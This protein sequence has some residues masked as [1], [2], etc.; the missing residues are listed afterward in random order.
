MALGGFSSGVIIDPS[1]FSVKKHK[2]LRTSYVRLRWNFWFDFIPQ[3]I[4]IR[5][6]LEI[7]KKEILIF[8]NV[9][10]SE[11]LYTWIFSKH[12][13][14]FW[15]LKT[16]GPVNTRV[17]D[18]SRKMTSS[19]SISRRRPNPNEYR[20]VPMSYRSILLLLRASSSWEKSYSP[21]RRA[22]FQNLNVTWT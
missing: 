3:R 21:W 11:R 6:K 1:A 9:I 10:G 20:L 18:R 13:S 19:S 12:F 14:F 8:R 15:N 16:A 17:S 2:W 5:K 4:K 7:P 22:K